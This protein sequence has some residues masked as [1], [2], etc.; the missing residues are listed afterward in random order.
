M[1]RRR[2]GSPIRPVR[3]ARTLG[4]CQDGSERLEGG[5]KGPCDRGAGA[6]VTD[7]DVNGGRITT[8]CRSRLSDALNVGWLLTLPR[9][10]SSTFFLSIDRQAPPRILRENHVRV[11]GLGRR[12]LCRALAPTPA[13]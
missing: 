6:S 11:F 10:A 12:A 2:I 13:V 1:E 4:G 9:P 8:F 7:L 5:A 3:W